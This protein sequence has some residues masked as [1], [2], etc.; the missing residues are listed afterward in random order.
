MFLFVAFPVF[1]MNL[2]CY[3]SYNQNAGVPAEIMQRKELLCKGSGSPHQVCEWKAAW[4]GAPFLFTSGILLVFSWQYQKR[5]AVLKPN[6]CPC[7]TWRY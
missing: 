4:R 5:S 3:H 6:V 1:D 2:E 7:K